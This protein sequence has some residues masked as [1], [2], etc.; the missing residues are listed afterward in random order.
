MELKKYD[1][2]RKKIQSKNFE[3][4]NESLSNWLYGLSFLGNG[5][6]IFFAYFSL[7]DNNLIFVSTSSRSLRCCSASCT[8][9]FNANVP[10]SCSK[11]ISSPSHFINR[12]TV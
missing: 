12:Q 7:R 10:E 9:I 3:E 2:L 8:N 11:E 5:G 1:R 4:K 6:S